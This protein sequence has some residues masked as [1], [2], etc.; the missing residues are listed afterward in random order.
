ME[1]DQIRR[2]SASNRRLT[3]DSVPAQ[4]SQSGYMVNNHGSGSSRPQLVGRSSSNGQALDGHRQ[5]R[6]ESAYNSGSTAADPLQYNHRPSL[7]IRTNS[8]DTGNGGLEPVSHVLNTPEARRS[9]TRSGALASRQSRYR[10]P[11]SSAAPVLVE[12]DHSEDD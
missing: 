7:Q 12:S 2:S 6:Q 9:I 8:Y 4:Q 10:G 11:G 5:R 1:E 3:T